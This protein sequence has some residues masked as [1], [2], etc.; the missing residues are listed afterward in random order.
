MASR[1]LRNIIVGSHNA[2]SDAKRTIK[3]HMLTCY[4]SYLICPHKTPFVFTSLL[5]ALPSCISA[6][7]S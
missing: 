5:I 3:D 4:A 7:C 2:G 1:N 6:D